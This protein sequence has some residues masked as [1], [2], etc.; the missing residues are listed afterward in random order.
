MQDVSRLSILAALLIL[1]A[2]S[3]APAQS[4]RE[5]PAASKLPAGEGRDLVVDLC[6]GACHSADKFINT[7]KTAR[8]WHTTVLE[9]VQHG[10]QLFPDD[11]ETI[12]KYLSIYFGSDAPARSP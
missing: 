4:G 1:G 3:A 9:M 2:I 7:R 5:D 12:S 6:A 11:V 8:E 10:A